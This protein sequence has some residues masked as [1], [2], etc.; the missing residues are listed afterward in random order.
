MIS[1]V[2]L[3]ANNLEKAKQFYEPLFALMGAKVVYQTERAIFFSKAL[4]EPMLSICTPFNKEPATFGNG[5]M[6]AIEAGSND[7]VD[8]IYAKAL[9]SGGTCEGKPGYR[10]PNVLYIAYF[11]D[12]DG[13]KLAFTHRAA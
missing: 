5:T 9:E 11:R 8:Q 1:Y 12:L 2:T 13:N 7:I 10:I 6:I 3:G 4:G